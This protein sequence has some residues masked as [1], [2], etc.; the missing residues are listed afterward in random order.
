MGTYNEFGAG[1]DSVAEVT[2]NEY[3]ALNQQARVK[4]AAGKLRGADDT[5]LFDTNYF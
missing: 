4:N 2:I 1:Y 3:N 5:W